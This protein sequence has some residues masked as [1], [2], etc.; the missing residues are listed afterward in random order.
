MCKWQN[1]DSIT[2]IETGQKSTCVNP[3]YH[4]AKISQYANN[5][6]EKSKETN[7]DKYLCIMA[8]GNGVRY[9]WHGK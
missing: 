8:N 4:N 7:L 9:D 2:D 1:Q 3:C 6:A 5:I